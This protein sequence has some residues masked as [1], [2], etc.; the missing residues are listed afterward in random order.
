MEINTHLAIDQRLCG[1]VVQVGPPLSIV[2]LDLTDGMKA[3]DRG[4]VHGGFIFGAADYA[5]MAAINDP[6]VVLAGANV[7]FLK[8]ARIGERLLFE[9]R[10]D[11]VDGRKHTVSVTGRSASGL[12]MFSGSFSCLVA[13]HHVF[14][15]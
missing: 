7:R 4:L 3:D 10:V 5:A 15:L 6:N 9:G 12:E 11:V 1:S 13:R 2:Q 14:D 8:P